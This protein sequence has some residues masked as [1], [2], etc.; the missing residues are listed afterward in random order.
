MPGY[1]VLD[2]E[3]VERS[4]TE[5]SEPTILARMQSL[6]IAASSATPGDD[7]QTVAYV[8]LGIAMVVTAIATVIITPRAQHNDH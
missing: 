5:L 6:F 3:Y 8:L 4:E 2:T 1:G 7:L